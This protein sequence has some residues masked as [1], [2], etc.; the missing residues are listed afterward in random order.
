RDI[1]R[2]PTEGEA[3]RLHASNLIPFDGGPEGGQAV[4]LVGRVAEQFRPTAKLAWPGPPTV[5]LGSRPCVRQERKRFQR[6]YLP[7]RCFAGARPL[8]FLTAGGTSI[9]PSLDEA[10]TSRFRTIPCS[11]PVSCMT[12][13]AIRSG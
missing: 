12:P 5:T 11:W 4:E 9:L 13:T 1:R 3:T 10:S 6:C 7:P 2:L 8:S